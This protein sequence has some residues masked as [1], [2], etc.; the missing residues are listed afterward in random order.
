MPPPP[1]LLGTYHP[2]LL[3]VGDRVYCKYRRTW[4]RVTSWTDAPISWPRVQP[5]KTRGGCGLVVG[6]TLLRAIRTECAAALTHWFSV[7]QRRKRCGIAR[8]D[9]PGSAAAHLQTCRKG[10]AAI[11][12]REWTGEEFDARAERSRRLGLRPTGRWTVGGW[13]WQELN[14]LGTA[15]EVVAKKIWRTRDAVRSRRANVSDAIPRTR[16]PHGSG[17]QSPKRR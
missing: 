1:P 16:P 9:A 4:C 7:R 3:K 8:T 6:P 10:G 2:P 17:R 12:S 14:L 15:A 13:R 11:R 5:L